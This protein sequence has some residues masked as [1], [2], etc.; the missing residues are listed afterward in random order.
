HLQRAV[1]LQLRLAALD[2]LPEGSA[3]I[4]NRLPEGVLLVDADARVIF[5]NISAKRMLRAG[6]GLILGHAGL[7]AEI[8]G[9]TRRLRQTIVDCALPRGDFGSAGGRFRL[10][11]EDRAPL[12]VL[13][14]PH[15]S[16]CTLVNVIR[17][18]AILLITDP[19][20]AVA[21]RRESL[22]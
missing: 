9:E 6:S 17:P 8:P 3:E 21:V 13:V 12:A 5:S 22:R 11:R 7:R 10:S 2:N 1:Q 19:E 14:V 4:L 20:D 16:S 15:R 18:R